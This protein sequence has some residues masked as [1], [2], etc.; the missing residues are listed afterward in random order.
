MIKPI[1]IVGGGLA[2]L[3]LGIGLRQKGIPTTIWEAGHYPRHRVCG[4]FISGAGQ[5]VLERLGLREKLMQAGARLAETASFQSSFITTRPLRLPQPALCLSRWILDELLARE[6]REAGGQ[7]REAQRWDKPSGEGIVLASGRHCQAIVDGWRWLGLKVHARNVSLSADLELHLFP[8]GYAGICR[9]AEGEVDVCALLRSRT[10]Y[11]DLASSWPERLRG[12]Q[13]SPLRARLA[14]AVF[15]P[16]SFCSVA[17]LDLRAH[18]ASEQAECRLGDAL[19]LIAPMTGNGMSMAFESAD[20]ATGPLIEY[21]RGQVSWDQAR[22]QIAQA[23]DQRFRWRLR[24]AGLLQWAVFH[25]WAARPCLSLSSTWT[26][27]WQMLFWR[28]RG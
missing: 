17:G 9:L 13:G 6:F 25:P 8:G 11:A 18:R 2:G 1:T 14:E 27:F 5:A 24:W 21:S 12:P 28:T 20:L 16:Q 7:L 15:D 26:P 3:T 22:R 19:T 23:C 4:E 10:A